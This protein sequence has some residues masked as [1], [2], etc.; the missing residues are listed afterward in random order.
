MENIYEKI[1]KLAVLLE[2][3]KETL[4]S[5]EGATSMLMAEERLE[6]LDEES[7]SYRVLGSLVV[8][9]ERID[10][11]LSLI[12]SS[13]PIEEPNQLDCL[14]IHKNQDWPDNV[15]HDDQDSW[16]DRLLDGM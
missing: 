15:M 8:D 4:K 14:E 10:R 12:T 1:G 13:L 5:L 2:L 9:L 7:M 3:K 16:L 11:R 6:S